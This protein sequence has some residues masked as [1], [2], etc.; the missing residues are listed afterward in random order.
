M[1]AGVTPPLKARVGAEATKKLINSHAT[2]IEELQ[3]EVELLKQGD[4]RLKF[5]GIED[6]EIVEWRIPA[7]KTDSDLS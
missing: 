3:K 2:G 4:Q 5:L 6:G 1:A 7:I